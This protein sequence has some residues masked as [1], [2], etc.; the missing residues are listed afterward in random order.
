M[1]LRINHNRG[2]LNAWRHLTNN[3]FRMNR[4]LERLSSGLRINSAADD[5]AGLSISEK[6]R[7]QVASLNQAVENSEQA[8]SMINTAEAALNEIHNLLTTMRE[9]SIHAANEGVND[10]TA[11]NA[12]QQQIQSS[13][14]TITRIANTTQFGTKNLLDGSTDNK[15]YTLGGAAIG[16]TQASNSTLA[17]GTHTLT[18]ANV[19]AAAGSYVSEVTASNAGLDNTVDPTPSGLTAGTHIVTVRAATSAFIESDQTLGETIIESG[20]IMTVTDG[21]NSAGITFASDTVNTAQNIADAINAGTALFVASVGLDGSLKVETA[22][23][24][25]TQQIAITVDGTNITR[26]DLGMSTLTGSNGTTATIQLGAGETQ[27]LSNTAGT[28]TLTDGL[29]GQLVLDTAATSQAAFA[30]ATLEISVSSAT[31]D[32]SLDNGDSVTMRSDVAGTVQSGLASGGQL[33]VVFGS[34]VTA[35]SGSISVLDNALVF[36]VGANFGQSV[37]IGVQD[38]EA[39]QLGTGVANISNFSNLNEI[40]VTTAQGAADALLL[41]DDAIDAVSSARAELGAFQRNTLESNL[42]NL[43]IAAEN[44]SSAES[45]FRDADLAL[46]MAEF[47]KLQ[48]LAQTGVAMMAQANQIPQTV[49]RLIG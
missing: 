21:T 40:D 17:S 32:V 3:D 45:T 33:S 47:T 18:V 16:L 11:L 10:E 39:S 6:L 43:R 44:L 15:V 38:M 49:L 37:K 42:A 30:S 9:L 25:G 22:D 46:E 41:I 27:E 19:T 29:G 5:P 24:G 23:V 26:A 35:G 36:Q 12:D 4:S 8:M 31:F 13:L 28:I 2:A 48:I 34:G 1:S 7:A 14:D 20:A